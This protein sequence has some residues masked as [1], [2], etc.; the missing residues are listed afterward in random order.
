MDALGGNL[1]DRG[2]RALAAGCDVLLHCSGFLKAPGE[3]LAEM[4]E[5][6]RAAGDLDGDALIR[7][8]RAK[9]AVTP[10]VEFDAEA[11]WAR[12]TDLL[13]QARAGV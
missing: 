9:A 11:G 12:L 5:V 8:R 2:A 3:I 10:G 1:A 7:A 13:M 4:D 6:A